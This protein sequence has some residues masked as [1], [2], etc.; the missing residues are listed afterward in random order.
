VEIRDPAELDLELDRARHEYNTVRL[1]AGIGYLT[2]DD[3]H[4]GRADPIRQARRDGLTAARAAR[5]AYR[6]Q[7]QEQQQ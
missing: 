1:H 7:Q 3:E 2:P 5:L 4:H 6:Q